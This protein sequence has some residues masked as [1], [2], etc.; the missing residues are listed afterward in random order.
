MAG[1]YRLR[2]ARVKHLAW[3]G[4]WCS[5]VGRETVGRK[6]HLTDDGNVQGVPLSYLDLESWG[7]RGAFLFFGNL[8]MPS[9]S[10]AIRPVP[11]DIPKGLQPRRDT[12]KSPHLDIPDRG[13]NRPY[14]AEIAL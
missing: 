7:G 2:H 3:L 6:L 13:I 5:L 14:V 8:E 11:W 9:F 4:F 1:P 10:E 12:K